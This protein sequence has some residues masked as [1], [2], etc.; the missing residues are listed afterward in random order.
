M[1]L[2]SDAYQRIFSESENENQV[3]QKYEELSMTSSQIRCR[4]Q[5]FKGFIIE[6]DISFLSDI[7]YVTERNT[8]MSSSIFRACS[9]LRIFDNESSNMW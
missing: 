8:T 7:A 1:T 9:T 2:K 6:I 5:T 3:Q 4:A